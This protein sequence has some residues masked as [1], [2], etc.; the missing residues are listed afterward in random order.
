MVYA[1]SKLYGIPSIGF[2]FFAV[3]GPVGHLD[4]TYVGFTNKLR[5]GLHRFAEYI[6][7]FTCDLWRKTNE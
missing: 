3:Y 6:K 5:V 1:Y 4:M 7:N 2:L